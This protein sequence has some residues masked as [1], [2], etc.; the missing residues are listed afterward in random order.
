MNPGISFFMP[1]EI[2][3]AQVS[4]LQRE[5]RRLQKLVDHQQLKLSAIRKKAHT[6]GL[7]E[8]A[9]NLIFDVV[10]IIDKK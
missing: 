7:A 6:H 2:P 4:R 10:S 3:S 9:A 8:L 5:N 1:R